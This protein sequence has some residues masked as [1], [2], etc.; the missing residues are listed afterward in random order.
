MDGGQLFCFSSSQC[1]R[2]RKLVCNYSQSRY[3]GVHNRELSPDPP[4]LQTKQSLY[5]PLSPIQTVDTKPAPSPTPA[6]A[7]VEAHELR[8]H[9]GDSR[10][11]FWAVNGIDFS[12]RAGQC[13]GLLGPNGAGKTT[14]LQMILG[15]LR[16]SA[17]QLKIFGITMSADS[18]RNR[19]PQI[20][21]RIGVVPQIDNLDPDFSVYENLDVYGR[22]FGLSSNTLRQRIPELLQFVELESR[23]KDK[24][25]TLSGGMQRR[26]TLARALIND[27]ELVV[28]DEPTTGLDPQIRHLMWA[29]LRD[30]VRQGKTLILTSH[31]MEEAERLCDQLMILD[32]G[33][34]ITE[35]DPASLV[36][37][38]IE[39][40]VIE[41]RGE[42]NPQLSK[43]AKQQGTRIERI[44][45]SQLYYSDNAAPLLECLQ[46]QKQ[47]AF[48][49]RP[50]NLE[51]VFLRLSGR[52]L[53]E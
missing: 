6:P 19:G 32:H 52:E 47:S 4:F 7:I 36:K 12:I 35:G 45:E 18:G 11:G 50:A 1:S 9:F 15:R 37:R 2:E 3:T 48:L 46:H 38:H 34:V 31:Y 5:L 33:K 13:Y 29:R 22:F 23:A 53:R 51:D 42:P 10:D 39:A 43:L 44:G 24:I 16:P 17:G 26:L 8:K 27:P 41:I 21:Q 14:T 25:G 20:R 28:L 30:L 49:H 40:E